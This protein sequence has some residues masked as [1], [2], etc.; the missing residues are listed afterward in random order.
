[1][2]A[3]AELEDQA[4]RTPP[5]MRTAQITD[6]R[7]HL[8]A[9]PPR[10]RLRRVRP[11]S[12]AIKTAIPVTGYPPVHSLASH[13]EALRDLSYRDAIQNLQ[14]GLVSLLDHVPLPKHCGSVAHQVKPRCRI[15][16]GA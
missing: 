9:D 1:V 13:S 7:F 6:Q 8:R 10:M 16:T 15:S 2:T 3:L 4:A 5:A 11:V 14:H 12:Q